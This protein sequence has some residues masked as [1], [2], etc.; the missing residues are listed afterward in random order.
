M[1][2]KFL[3]IPLPVIAIFL[4]IVLVGGAAIAAFLWNKSVPCTVTIIG[5][6][7]EA[8]EDSGCTIELTALD[9]GDLRA[10]EQTD[11]LSFYIKNIGDDPLYVAIATENLDSLLTLYEGADLLVPADPA[12]LALVTGI[13]DPF[14]Q[15]TLI[16][17]TLE[18]AVNDTDIVLHL[19]GTDF[20]DQAPSPGVVRVESELIYYETAVDVGSHVNLS[21]CQRGYFGTTAAAH[22]SGVDVVLQELVDDALDYALDPGAVL[23][24]PTYLV[25]DITITRGDQPFNLILES[26]DTPYP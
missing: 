10:G 7:I 13:A 24:V 1:K 8:Y 18:G 6:D 20:D 11:P 2:K 14:Y 21:N 15:D 17:T 3:G 25:A 9:Y 19:A 16:S 4:A 12:R 26:M 23:E 22:A 5:A